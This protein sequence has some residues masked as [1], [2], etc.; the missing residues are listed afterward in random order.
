MHDLIR[1]PSDEASALRTVF[2]LV[3]QGVFVID[4]PTDRIVDVNTA[5]CDALGR[6]LATLIGRSWTSTAGRLGAMTLYDI[7]SHGRQ[8][9]AIPGAPISN[10]PSGTSVLR[11]SLTGLANREALRVCTKGTSGKVSGSLALLFIDLNGFEQINDTW[12]HIAGDG[13]LRIVA[14][15]LNDSVR[16]G[17]LVVRYGGDE[18]LVVV[19]GVTR[20]RDLERLARQ[21]ARA[22][23]RPLTVAG[24]PASVT[25]SIGIAQRTRCRETVDALIAEAHRAMYQVKSESRAEQL[26]YL[27]SNPKLGMG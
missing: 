4:R 3:S 16:P 22:V 26:P 21:I 5:G 20:R 1:S 18:F 23:E 2:E 24:Q 8:F 12:G 17:D 7:D 15:R 13:V 10:G 25:A 19:E 9:L 6:R 14:Q 27:K 11:D